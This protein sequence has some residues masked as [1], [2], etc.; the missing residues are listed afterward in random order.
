MRLH[1]LRSDQWGGALWVHAT[2]PP[3]QVLLCASCS[4]QSTPGTCLPKRVRVGRGR[5]GLRLAGAAASAVTAPSAAHARAR[6]MQ[7]AGTPSLLT[8][9]STTT[10]SCRRCLRRRA[11]TSTSVREG[12]GGPQLRVLPAA[13]APSAPLVPADV[14]RLMRG[15]YQDNL[16]NMQ[17]FKSFFGAR[18]VLRPAVLLCDLLTP[19]PTTHHHTIRAQL[20][21]RPV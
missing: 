4:T 19:L 17:W 20:Q 18:A 3:L 21:G 16:E 9:S 5:G 10:R 13:H 15:K 8:S 11:S 7:C 12:C 14:E 1:V 6:P 2:P